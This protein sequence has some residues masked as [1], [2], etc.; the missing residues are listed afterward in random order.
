[1][2][3]LASTIYRGQ[4]AIP[5]KAW[6]TVGWRESRSYCIRYNPAAANAPGSD[7]QLFGEK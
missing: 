5:K 1:M 4:A 2:T 7:E 3:G 6:C